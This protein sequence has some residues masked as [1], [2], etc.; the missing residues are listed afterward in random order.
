MIKVYVN[1]RAKANIRA[2]RLA[3]EFGGDDSQYVVAS[4]AGT[5]VVTR[6]YALKTGD[7]LIVS[8]R[9]VGG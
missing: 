6:T 1:G 3:S 2:G 5:K 8:K 7:T 9:G 4:R